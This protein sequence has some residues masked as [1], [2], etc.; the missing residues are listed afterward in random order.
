VDVYDTGFGVAE[1]LEEANAIG[2]PI[3]LKSSSG[4]P[5]TA[6]LLNLPSDFIVFPTLSNVNVANGTA[7]ANYV[8]TLPQSILNQRNGADVY[9]FLATSRPVTVNNTTVTYDSSDV[10]IVVDESFRLIQTFDSS[11]ETDLFY[12]AIRLADGMNDA[13]N[14][15][16]DYSVGFQVVNGS[17]VVSNFLG[18]VAYVTP[19]P[20]PSTAALLVLGLAALAARRRS[21]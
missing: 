16:F 2:I 10:G 15:E 6:R 4:A 20:E 7:L 21:A 1:T 8:I 3:I 18:G 9:L 11:N 5:N 14:L 12:P 19:I 17:P 13:F